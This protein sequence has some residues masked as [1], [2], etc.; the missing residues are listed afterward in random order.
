MLNFE[1][2]Y[3]QT[4]LVVVSIKYQLDIAK[5]FFYTDISFIDISIFIINLDIN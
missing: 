3:S 5:S 4:F 2:D 1:V